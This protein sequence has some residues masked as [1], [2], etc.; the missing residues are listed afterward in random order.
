MLHAQYYLVLALIVVV[1][2]LVEILLPTMVEEQLEMMQMNRRCHTHYCHS[3]GQ[4]IIWP[5]TLIDLL[6]HKI[7]SLWS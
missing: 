2:I 4:I 6:T 1:H 7:K 3:R 5:H